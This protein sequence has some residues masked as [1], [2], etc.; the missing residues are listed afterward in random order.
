VIRGVEAPQAASALRPGR[1]PDGRAGAA[2][3]LEEGSESKPPTHFPVP[4]LAEEVAGL[5]LQ[6]PA[7]LI[8]CA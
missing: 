2:A 4:L 5:A 6:R 8:E 1:F 7:Q 3:L